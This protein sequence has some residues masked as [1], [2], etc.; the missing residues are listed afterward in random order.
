[1]W[2]NQDTCR[3]LSRAVDEGLMMWPLRRVP[4][5]GKLHKSAYLFRVGRVLAPGGSVTQIGVTFL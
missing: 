2:R 4:A 3:I 5:G 1:M